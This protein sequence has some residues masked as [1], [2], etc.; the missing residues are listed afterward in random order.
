MNSHAPGRAAGRR[1]RDDR[2]V[3]EPRLRRRQ[4]QRRP[5]LRPEPAGGLMLAPLT[6]TLRPRGRCP[7]VPRRLTAA[8]RRGRRR[9]DARHRA[10]ADGVEVDRDAPRRLRQRLRLHAC[11][12]TLPADLPARARVPAAHGADDRRRLPVRAVGLVHIANRIIQHRPIALGETLDAARA[13]DAAASRTRRGRTFAFVTEARVGGELVWEERA[14]EARA[15][16]AATDA[17]GEARRARRRERGRRPR[18][19]ASGRC[20][21]TSA[22]A[23]PPSPATA[24]RSTCTR[25][26]REAVRLPARDRPRDVDQGALP[27][28]ARGRL[29]DAFTRRG[30][31]SSKPILLPGK[32]ELLSDSGSDEIHFAVRDQRE[33]L[34]LDGRIEPIETQ[35]IP[36]G[37]G[38][39]RSE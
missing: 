25:C 10:D 33:Q 19:S 13:R 1:R 11:A 35:D 30:R 29:P 39:R 15:A 38:G 18:P 27:R 22:A 4:R 2:V 16:A 17:G 20:A 23:T 9:R 24:T 28:R 32:V 12:T 34:H 3:R 5:R 37:T 8:V 6:R 21:A 36:N 26:Q 31:G 7:L 14:H